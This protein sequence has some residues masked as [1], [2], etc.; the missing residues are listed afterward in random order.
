MRSTYGYSLHRPISSVGTHTYADIHTSEFHVVSSP[1]V[2]A[3]DIGALPHPCSVVLK[4]L[5]YVCV[6]IVY[7]EAK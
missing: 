4:I 3:A 6:V 1:S 2:Q 5:P 7:G